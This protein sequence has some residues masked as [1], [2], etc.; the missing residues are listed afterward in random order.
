MEVDPEE[1]EICKCGHFAGLW[2]ER[3]CEECPCAKFDLDMRA[4]Y[5]NWCAEEATW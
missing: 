3:H 2:P 5:D 4:T 1:D